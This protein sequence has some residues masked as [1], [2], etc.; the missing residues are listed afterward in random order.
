VGRH[1]GEHVTA[2]EGAGDG[3]HMVSRVR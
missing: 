1:R 2:V 3:M